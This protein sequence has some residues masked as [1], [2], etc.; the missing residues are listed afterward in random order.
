VRLDRLAPEQEARLAA[1]REEWRGVGLATGPSDRLRAERGMRA[2]YLAAGLPPPDL[3]L[4]V[5]SPL[6][7]VLGTMHLAIT[8]AGRDRLAAAVRAAY[9]DLVGRP[10][11]EP[12]G[13]VWA[14]LGRRDDA[15]TVFLAR[16]MV[17]TASVRHH[18]A[19]RLPSQVGRAA[20]ADIG[21]RVAQQVHRELQ[22]DVRWHVVRRLW[23]P[24]VAEIQ[25]AAW[26]RLK[27]HVEEDH[28][29]RWPWA[30]AWAVVRDL[31]RLVGIQD[32]LHAPAAD[33][34]TPDWLAAYDFLGRVCGVEAVERLS[35]LMELSRA[36]GWWWWP[37]RG[38]VVLSE[39]PERLQL[40]EQGR[41]HGARG[42]ALAFPDGW[43][44][45]AWHGVRVPRAVIENP[46]SLP[47]A[48]VLSEPDVEVRR[49]MIE[50]V[51]HERLIRDGG[52]RRVAEDEMGILWQLDLVEDE[53]L[54]CVEVTDATPGPDS[55]FKRY[56]LR[57]P[58][59]VRTPR[60]AVAWT[61]GVD[62]GEY[63]P[64]IET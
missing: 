45:W 35:G 14:P 40:D 49:V 4:W 36:A 10:G 15:L 33:R 51:G 50:R 62:T 3:F 37:Q 55:A 30:R 52:A 60:E 41:L 39:R 61:F 22:G 18:V 6:E 63:R 59:S 25:T 5:R 31:Y 12:W 43:S 47:A 16:A 27:A 44:L 48:E 54:V 28:A 56:L 17:N 8:G 1:I 32:A 13:R 9:L 7:G 24:V 46:E 26:Q 58:P 20:R 53:P 38:A 42:P 11:G 19:R 29:R 23:A 57:V 2:A 64:A 21:P 34:A